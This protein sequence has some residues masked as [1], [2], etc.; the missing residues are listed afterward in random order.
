MKKNSSLRRTLRGAAL[1]DLVLTIFAANGRLL[2]FGDNMVSDLSLTA[3]RWQVLG[4]VE[5]TPKTVAQIA[6]DFELTRQGVLWVVRALLK[7]GLVE[8]ITNPDHRRAKLVRHTAKGAAVYREINRR[9]IKWINELSLSFKL[10][11]IHAA[12]STVARLGAI[13]KRE[14]TFS[15]SD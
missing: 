2:S 5:R 7:A 12:I 13:Q 9:Q 8:L 14:R 15:A 11:E 4:A 6:R 3:A 10:N 1:T